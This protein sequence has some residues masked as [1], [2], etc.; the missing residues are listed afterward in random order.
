M[1]KVF[2]AAA[3]LATL[4]LAGCQTQYQLPAENTEAEGSGA[5]CADLGLDLGTNC[6]F[7]VLEQCRA[8]LS[9]I[10]GQCYPNP[11]R[12]VTR[13]KATKPD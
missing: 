13:P 6:G 2:I 7:A 3:V 8:A 1:S 11:D 12:A 10:S 9:G 5:W 4:A